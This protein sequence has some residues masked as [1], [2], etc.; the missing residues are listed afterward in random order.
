MKCWYEKNRKLSIKIISGPTAFLYRYSF[1]SSDKG[2]ELS[3]KAGAEKEGLIEVL[4][5]KARIAPE[6]VLSGLVKTGSRRQFPDVKERAR[7]TLIRQELGRQAE[8]ESEG[9]G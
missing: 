9:G 4:G 8:E 2:T 5:T 1:K 3:L 6:F 7:V